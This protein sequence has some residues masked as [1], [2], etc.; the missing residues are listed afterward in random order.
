MDVQEQLVIFRS[1]LEGEI[2]ACR[3]NIN[4]T[5][6]YVR[7]NWFRLFIIWHSFQ[8]FNE[9]VANIIEAL[10]ASY[11]ESYATASAGWQSIEDGVLVNIQVSEK[12]FA[13]ISGRIAKC[14]EAK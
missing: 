6:N 14:F 13:E 4:C 2:G 8:Q 3:K 1:T 7:K 11:T 10:K 5:L 9:N 12:D